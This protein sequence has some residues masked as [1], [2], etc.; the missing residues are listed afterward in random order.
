MLRA[1]PYRVFFP[2]GVLCGWL[3]ASHWFFYGFGFI[4]TY[5]GLGHAL[6]MTEA[7]FS[8]FAFGFL[9]T[10]IPRRTETA[11]ASWIEI[12][13]G[14]AGIAVTAVAANRGEFVLAEYGFVGA[15]SVLLVFAVRRTESR[16]AGRRPPNAFV[17]I[18]IG[19]AAGIAGAVLITRMLNGQGSLE[20]YLIGRELVQQGVFLCF[21][22]GVGALILPLIQGIETPPDRAASASHRLARL[23]YAAAGV[24]IIASLIADPWWPRAMTALRGAIVIAALFAGRAA[25]WPKQPGLHRRVAVIAVALAPTGLLAAA[26]FPRHTVAALHIMYIGS[27]SLLALSIATH[28]T[29]GH[30]GRRDLLGGNPVRVIAI[31]VFVLAA[32]AMRVTA[33]L[34]PERYYEVIGVAALVWIAGSVAFAAILLGTGRSAGAV[35]LAPSR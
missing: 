7:M 6:I 4:S 25:R 12:I 28:V 8:A 17:L 31:A 30:G 29:L 14:A 1:N 34:W 3:G 32:M 21:L 13:L 19:A 5:S 27:L 24:A 23:G 16:S 35:E 11:P 26:A 9:M 20:A 15:M 2:L 33:H 18:P 10:A 22:L